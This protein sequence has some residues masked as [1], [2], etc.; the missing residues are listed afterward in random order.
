MNVVIPKSGVGN[1]LHQ[2]DLNVF[3]APAVDN[4]SI[5]AG[6]DLTFFGQFS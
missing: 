5:P 1:T 6:S 2:T 4:A 3:V